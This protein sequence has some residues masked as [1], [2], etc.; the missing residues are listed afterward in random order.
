MSPWRWAPTKEGA[1]YDLPDELKPIA[2]VKDQVCVLSG[3]NAILDGKA[4]LVHSSGLWGLRTGTVPGGQ[5]MVQIDL[6]SI[7]VLIGDAIGTDTRFRSLEVTAAGDPKHTYSRRNASVVNPS[8]PSRSRSI[9]RV[10]GPEFLDPNAGEF[11]PDPRV[12]LRQSVLSAVKHDRDAFAR[13]LGAEDKARL[14]QYFTSL[15]Q[16]E[17]QLELQLQKP[18]PAEACKVPGKPT[19]GTLGVEI[20]QS[21]ANHKLMAQLM[22]MALACNQTKMFNIAFSEAASTL[23]K[24]GSSAIHHTLTHEEEIDKQVGYQPTVTWFIQQCMEQF[25][26]FVGALAAIREG[27][28]TLLDNCMVLAHSDVSFAKVHD[29]TGVP[30]M[31]AGK[32]GGKIK[33]GIHVKGNGDPLTRI[34]LTCQQVMGVPVD[35]WGTQSMQTAKPIGEILA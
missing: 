1:N 11:K 15:R 27:D 29:I 10:F 17:Q 9:P 20:E 6:S 28:G 4:N 23:H 31:I 33:P 14:D 19:E 22:A 21:V 26:T 7:D 25:A 18:P 32:A 24:A 13:D 16:T 30:A 12:M 35:R 8:E 3:F 2:P 5:G 34:G